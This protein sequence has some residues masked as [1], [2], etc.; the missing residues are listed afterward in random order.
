MKLYVVRRRSSWPRVLDPS[1]RDGDGRDELVRWIRSYVVREADGRLG[2]V[3]VYQGPDARS[4]RRH[5]ERG[6]LPVAEI[7]EV[8]DTVLLRPDAV[9]VEVPA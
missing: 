8:A 3:C 7:V 2:T 9:A 1:R 5:A 4:V 6:G